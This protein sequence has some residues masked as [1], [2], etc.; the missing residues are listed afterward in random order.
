MDE[1]EIKI[2]ILQFNQEGN[3]SI[4]INLLSVDEFSLD[5]T[6]Y[7]IN[8]FSD[9][10][11]LKLLLFQP[12]KVSE[13]YLVFINS[14]A[15]IEVA[16]MDIV[17]LKKVLN[18]VKIYDN[19]NH[20][21]EASSLTLRS[22]ILSISKSELKSYDVFTNFNTDNLDKVTLRSLLKDEKSW[23]SERRETQ[24]K[25]IDF[26][27]KSAEGLSR[28]IAHSKKIEKGIYCVRGS[29]ASGKSSFI[30]DFL[31]KNIK[32]IESVDGVLNTDAIK[33]KL[34]LNTLNA[35]GNALSGYMF[36]E[37]AS[38]LGEKILELVRKAKLLY[39][40][41][42]R[43]QATSDIDELLLDAERRKLPVTI[44]I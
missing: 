34:I 4:L 10:R 8:K 25:I 36:H 29:I 22:T 27:F 17:N 3:V 9:R 42:K 20:Q 32:S 41:D 38:I 40:I 18:K 12:L 6:I 13:K 2:K 14:S 33:R 21:H 7:F 28:K 35:T 30:K 31:R 26:Y 39:I 1:N 44:L 5:N 37:E 16:N 15:E 11:H 43:M 19:D 24:I 23:I